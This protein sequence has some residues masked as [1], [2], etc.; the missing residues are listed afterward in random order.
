MQ[1]EGSRMIDLGCREPR[2]GLCS[3]RSAAQTATPM[4]PIHAHNVALVRR[5]ERIPGGTRQND[6]LET[7][8]MDGGRGR[9]MRVVPLPLELGRCTHT[10]EPALRTQAR[11]EN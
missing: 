7:G 10:A 3:D 6:G 8:M 9:E 11:K 1:G 5:I 4:R 2:L